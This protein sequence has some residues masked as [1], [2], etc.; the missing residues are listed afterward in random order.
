MMGN[1]DKLV[2]LIEVL[3]DVLEIE[4]GTLTK[5]TSRENLE[6]WDSLVHL[7]MI[8]EVEEHFNIKIPFE[9]IINI[10]KIADFL[11]YIER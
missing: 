3:A 7:Q 2:E 8:A 6:E 5:E 1:D 11:K 10:H 4:S 9:D